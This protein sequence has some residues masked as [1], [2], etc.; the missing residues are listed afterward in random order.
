MPITYVEIITSEV[1]N[2]KERDLILELQC[3]LDTAIAMK[4]HTEKVCA[5]CGFC[6]NAMV[7]QMRVKFNTSL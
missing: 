6:T 5:T 2:T 7:K 3:K 4:E 1:E